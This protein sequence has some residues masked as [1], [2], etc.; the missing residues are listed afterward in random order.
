MLLSHNH[1]LSPSMHGNLKELHKIGGNV[2]FFF[3][4]LLFFETPLHARLKSNDFENM[5][6][7]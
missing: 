1:R 7:V 6:Q 2:Y 5:R 4:L 3:F